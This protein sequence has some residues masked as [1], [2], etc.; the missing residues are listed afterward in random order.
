[1][2]FCKDP[3]RFFKTTRVEIVFFPEGRENNPDNIIE[4]PAIKGPVPQMIQN[5]LNYLRTNVVKERILKVA[6]DE[7]ALKC[8]NYPYPALE[9]AVVNALY[10]R[11]YQEREPVEITV[12]PDKIS[13]LSYAGPDRS[14]SLEAVRAAKSL[15]SRRYRNRR[16]GEFLKE[17]NLT[18]GRAT[19]IPTIQKKLE[20]N[21]S[22]KATIETDEDRTYFLIDIPCHPAFMQEDVQDVQDMSKI[23]PRYVQDESV[24]IQSVIFRLSII[25]PRYFQDISKIFPRYFQVISKSDYEKLALCIVRCATPISAKEMLDN[26]EDITFKQLK[27]K[28]LQPLLDIGLI[29]MTMPDKPTSKN[30]RYILTEKGKD[31]LQ[32][33][34][35]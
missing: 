31:I 19:G 33:V 25:L 8:F 35:R 20:Q 29:A 11:D 24:D 13:I 22:P 9:E 18:E 26:I 5:T 12:E 3:E 34:N 2:M 14:I 16:L 1:M 32:S 28:Y 30:Q 10:H 23:C 6:D 7:H 4:V 15:R 21:G 17:L 27:N